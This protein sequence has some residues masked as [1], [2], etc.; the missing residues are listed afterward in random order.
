M[1]IRENVRVRGLVLDLIYMDPE[2]RIPHS[3]Y[4]TRAKTATFKGFFFPEHLSTISFQNLFILLEENTV[5]ANIKRT[6]MLPF[7]K[8]L[9]FFLLIEQIY[10]R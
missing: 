6:E 1:N 10:R 2:R 5:K 8:H 3:S 9:D 7:I 4:N